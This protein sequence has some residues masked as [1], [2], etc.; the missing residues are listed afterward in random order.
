MEE[1]MLKFTNVRCLLFPLISVIT[2]VLME[3]SAQGAE[4]STRRTFTVGH[5]IRRLNVRG[6]LGEDRPLDVHLWYPGHS[7]DDCENSGNSEGSRDDQGC[8]ATPSVYTSRLHGIL[9][10]P[11]WDPLSGTIGTSGFFMQT[12]IARLTGFNLHWYAW[13]FLSIAA[14]F[15]LARIGV[16]YSSRVLG[17]SLVLE[18][19]ILVIFDISVLARTG[20]SFSV[21]TPSIV[22]SGSLPIGLLLAATGFLAISFPWLLPGMHAA[23]M[24]A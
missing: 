20:Y 4:V 9:L 3:V 18:T 13:G 8:S 22:S 6:T 16:D 5:S 2:L 21:F 7:L 10:L 1:T 23:G 14:C 24:H 19:L 12:I 11:Q 15:V 17:V